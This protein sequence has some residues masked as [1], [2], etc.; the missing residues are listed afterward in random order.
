MTNTVENKER[1]V[2]ITALPNS[3]FD[4]KIQF[5]TFH[6]GS[7]TLWKINAPITL[8]HSLEAGISDTKTYFML[9]RRP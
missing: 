2:S 6:A 4:T 5:P 8:M 1:L 3:L 9:W 7:F